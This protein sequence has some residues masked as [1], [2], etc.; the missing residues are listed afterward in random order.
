MI[1]I[2]GF[3]LLFRLKTFIDEVLWKSEFPAPEET[4]EIQ[5]FNKIRIYKGSNFDD[6][7]INNHVEHAVSLEIFKLFLLNVKV[8]IYIVSIGDVDMILNYI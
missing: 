3:I 6:I 4:D 7:F 8:C 5:V 2:F 1:F